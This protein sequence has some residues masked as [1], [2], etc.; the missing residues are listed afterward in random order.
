MAQVDE[1][2]VESPNLVVTVTMVEKYALEVV[3]ASTAQDT[4]LVV[5]SKPLL[6]SSPIGHTS[7]V[8]AD[9]GLGELLS[10]CGFF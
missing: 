4:A 2:I 6:T 8:Q 1:A 5:V 10:W 9:H 7:S 3:G